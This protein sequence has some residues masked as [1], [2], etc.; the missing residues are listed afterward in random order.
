MSQ[1]VDGGLLVIKFYVVSV[2]YMNKMSDY[3]KNCYYNYCKKMEDDV[4]FF[5]MFYWDFMDCYCDKF[6]N[7]VCIGMVY[8]I[9]DCYDD[10]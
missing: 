4:C 8:C 7:N 6:E 3:C 2:N 10:D 1:Y 5:N 9:W